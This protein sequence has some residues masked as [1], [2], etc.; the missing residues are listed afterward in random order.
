MQ[1]IATRAAEA[2]LRALGGTTVM[3]RIPAGAATTPPNPGLGLN[4]PV[5]DD[6]SL[7]PAILRDASAAQV[8]ESRSRAADPGQTN[9]AHGYEAVFP[10]SALEPYLE[11][12]GLCAEDFLA[13]A[14]GIV[15]A[16]ESARFEAGAVEPD[17]RLLR[18]TG[19]AIERFAGQEY[20]VTL[21]LEE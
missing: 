4:A 14:Y 12:S 5:T 6:I 19:I 13:S 17:S 18:I 2:M 11:R 15:Q 1:T 8:P 16:R 9:S 21:Q 3:L 20:L 7:A 10:A